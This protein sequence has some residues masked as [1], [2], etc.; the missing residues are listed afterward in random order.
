MVGVLTQVEHPLAQYDRVLES[1][2]IPSVLRGARRAVIFAAA[3]ERNHQHVVIERALA[4]GYAARSWI[5]GADR[6]AAESEALVAADVA[7]GLH[8]VPR[9]NIARGDLRQKWRK[10]EEIFFAD[11][12]DLRFAAETLLKFHG[13]LHAAKPATEHDDALAHTPTLARHKNGGWAS[14]DTEA[15]KSQ[16]ISGRDAAAAFR[17]RHATQMSHATTAN[18]PIHP[19]TRTAAPICTS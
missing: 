16:G 15:E 13:G 19:S 12:H 3:A 1:F 4:Q 2:K 18:I 11:Q 17:C 10:Q 9:I 14:I 7:N 6:V 5:D 8:D